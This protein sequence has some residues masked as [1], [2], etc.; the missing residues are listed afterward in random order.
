MINPK[1]ILLVYPEVPSNTY[2]SFKY[3]LQF[4]QKKSAMPPLGLITVAGLIP[5]RYR[6]KLVDLNIEPLDDA[7]LQW[8]DLVFVSAMIVQKASLEAVIAR[9]NRVGAPV[10]AGGPYPTAGPSEIDG[11][12]HFILGEAEEIM[13]PFFEDLERGCAKKAYR[14]PGRPD[15]SRTATPRFD[16]LDLESYASMAVQ[17]SRGCPFKCEFCD[18]WPMYGN[19]PRLKPA[20]RMTAEL[21]ALCEQGWRGPVFIVDDNFIGNKGRVKKELLPALA[22]WQKD[23]G[24]PFTFYTEA[25]INMADDE[26]LLS[27]MSKVGFT[28]VFIGIETPSPE[29]LQETGKAQNLRTDMEAAVRKIQTAGIGVMGGFILGFDS[30]TED[31]FD[32]Q[33]DFIQRTGIPKAMMGLLTALPGTRLFQRLQ[34]ENRLIG[35]TSGNN[36]HHMLTNFKTH[37]DPIPLSEGYKRVLETIYDPDLKNYFRRCNILLDRLGPAR[38]LKHRGGIA[39]LSIFLKSIFRQ[40]FTPYGYQYLKFLMRNFFKHRDRITETVTYGIVGHHFHTITREFLKTQAISA[41][42]DR[43]Y[44]YFRE[45]LNLYSDSVVDNSKE[46]IQQVMALW[47]QQKKA[48]EDLGKRIEK[49]HVDFRGDVYSKYNRIS[50]RMRASV[51][52]FEQH[53]DRCGGAST[54]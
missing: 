41:V 37:M 16:L 14:S 10:V 2:W 21:D 47:E 33:I 40:P 34:R 7:D 31:I 43:K 51:R 29:G 26:A 12:D 36:T 17:Y 49:I 54:C 11:V 35:E 23:R 46:A 25:S 3:A 24:F 19:K 13:G 45:Q 8:A 39:S 48:L 38:T 20:E 42:L 1:N 28:E 9:C 30:D 22:D 4:I 52:R 44:A 50:E 6:M 18:I 5:D 53:A 27:G 32:R 15:L